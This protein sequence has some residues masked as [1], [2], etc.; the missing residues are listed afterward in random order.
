[1]AAPKLAAAE[2]FYLLDRRT[3][4]LPPTEGRT[5]L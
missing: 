3:L 1:M 5:G 4:P 2:P